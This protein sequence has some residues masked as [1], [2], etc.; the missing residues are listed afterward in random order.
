MFEHDPGRGHEDV[1]E[2][3]GLVIDMFARRHHTQALITSLSINVRS[4]LM[5]RTYAHD[6]QLYGLNIV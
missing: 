1:R 5:L 3:L 2:D 4:A 6:S